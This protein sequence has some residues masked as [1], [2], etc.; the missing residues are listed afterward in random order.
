MRKED[1]LKLPPRLDLNLP[2]GFYLER[3]P[4]VYVLYVSYP[5]VDKRHS[6]RGTMTDLK[7]VFTGDSTAPEI[8]EYA[9]AAA[10]RLAQRLEHK[11][12]G[13]GNA[14]RNDNAGN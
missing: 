6:P 1:K 4:G 5:V 2:E 7:G 9:R 8:E 10:E 13:E 14:G 12:E 3:E 11:H